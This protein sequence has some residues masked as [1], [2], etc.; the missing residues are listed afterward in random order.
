MRKAFEGRRGPTHGMPCLLPLQLV[1]RL[2]KKHCIRC[3]QTSRQI[4][5]FSLVPIGRET[6]TITKLSDL[7]TVFVK[8]K[9]WLTTAASNCRRRSPSRSKRNRIFEGMNSNY[10]TIMFVYSGWNQSYSDL[11][12]SPPVDIVNALTL[13]GSPTALDYFAST[14]SILHGSRRLTLPLYIDQMK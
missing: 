5:Y 9:S 1:E 7:Q 14:I 13:D 4:V 6:Y 10:V 3:K 11:W 8:T 2:P 12:N